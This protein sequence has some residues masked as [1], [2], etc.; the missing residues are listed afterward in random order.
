MILITILALVVIMVIAFL[1]LVVS[2]MGAAGIII[3]GDVI[4]ACFAVA[5]IIRHFVKKK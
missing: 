4:V 1:V 5:C 3:F 2:T